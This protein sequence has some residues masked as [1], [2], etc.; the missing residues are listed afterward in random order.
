MADF[1]NIAKQFTEFYY[2]LFDNNRPELVSLYRNNSMLTFETSPVQ[3]ATNIVQ[4]LVDLPFKNVKHQISTQDAQPSNEAGGI[5]VIV[6][7]AL[8]GE[9]RPMSYTQTFQLLPEGG[10]YFVFND[11]FR[12]VYPASS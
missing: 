10:S 4:K 6:T 5:L 7:G 11:I 2:N 3:G 1:E 12:L 8:L 9:T